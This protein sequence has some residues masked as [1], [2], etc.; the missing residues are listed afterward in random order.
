MSRRLN[1]LEHLSLANLS[2]QVKYLRVRPGAYPRGT[3]LKDTPENVSLL[4]NVRLDWKGLP[5]TSA[6]AY[7]K[8]LSVLKQKCLI[9]FTTD[10]F[11]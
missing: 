3:H 4:T 6:L 5:G 2:I 7:F 11:L 8:S 10:L 9:T 1:K